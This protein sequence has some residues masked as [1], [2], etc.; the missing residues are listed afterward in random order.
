[1]RNRAQAALF[2]GILFLL[3]VMFS[4]SMIYAYLTTYGVAQERT[5][6]SSHEINYMQTIVK[7]L[8]AVDV[9][10][11]KN[12]P[13]WEVSPD[14]VVNP[15]YADLNCSVLEGYPGR[16]SVAELLKKD[17][18]DYSGTA[19]GDDPACTARSKLDDSF[20]GAAA[21]GTTALRCALKE[22]MKPFTFA[23]I[24]YLAEVYTPFAGQR[25]PVFP[26]GGSGPDRVAVSNRPLSAEPRVQ[27]CDD[28]ANAFNETLAVRAPFRIRVD[29]DKSSVPGVVA[30]TPTTYT[31]TLR[32]C[33]WRR[34]R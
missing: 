9:S 10:A 24:Q 22:F 28:A 19:C 5:L 26:Q 4:V 25:V 7:S 32:F 31:Y 8:Y 29:I 23:G 12:V 1:M 2:D 15:A 14:E 18:S 3:L 6:R 27:T 11:L 30:I 13:Q 21:P 20:G 16:L 34:A 17:L 33:T